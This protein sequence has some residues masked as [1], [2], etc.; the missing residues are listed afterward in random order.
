[1]PSLQELINNITPDIYTSLKQAVE[2]G[3]WPNGEKLSQEQRG[4]CLQAVIAW[5]KDNLPEE[6]RTGYIPPKPSAC[7]STDNAQPLIL[8]D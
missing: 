8:R 3:K 6:Q 5:E 7:H 2:I 1:M 4:L